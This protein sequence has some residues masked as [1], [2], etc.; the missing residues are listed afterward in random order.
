MRLVSSLTELLRSRAFRRIF[1]Y[2][3]VTILLIWGIVLFGISAMV[4]VR[5]DAASYQAI[6]GILITI[7]IGA[8]L[9]TR[10]EIFSRNAQLQAEERA[11][12]LTHNDALTSLSNR[13]QFNQS[14]NAHIERGASCSV[15]L[16]DLD[17][18]RNVNEVY[19]H[20][21]GDQVLSN[22]AKRL[23]A[24]VEKYGGQSAR[25]G[26][27]EFAALVPT[28]NVTKL[29]YLCD[30]LVESTGELIR[31]DTLA[32]QPGTSVGVAT[33]AEVAKRTEISAETM[34]RAADFALSDA[35]RRGRGTYRIYDQELAA[36]HSDNRCILDELPKAFENGEFFV[37][38]QPKVDLG[39]NTVCGF[40]ALIRWNRAGNVVPPDLFIPLAE[41]TRQV[42]QMDLFVLGEA[43]RQ[44]GEWNREFDLSLSISANL[45]ARHFEDF[46]IID[47][48]KFALVRAQ[49]D[50][51]LLTLELTETV[52]LE[53]WDKV[54]CILEQ[55][56]ELGCRTSLDDFG[57][58][59]SS[60][61][62]LRRI[63]ADELKIDRAFVIDIEESSETRVI[64]NS[65]VDI[66]RCLGMNIV[67]EGIE[68][69]GQAKIAASVGCDRAQGYLYSAPVSAGTVRSLFLDADGSLEVSV[70]DNVDRRASA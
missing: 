49:L 56:R 3:T 43:A 17:N 13:A 69:V 39:T 40:E 42:I 57:T 64:L 60:L 19:G 27:D 55:L 34:Y 47:E 4:L 31:K 30:E 23:H 52:L 5:L 15:L 28:H 21:F 48:V 14:L 16:L 25:L 70:E 41:E 11:E 68:T 61:A 2:R 22:T 50:P 59:Y 36:T 33:S 53:D 46:R 6:I 58:G 54:H 38:Y 35:K 65:I 63:K 62:Y 18:F 9:T 32:F 37:A 7:G 24:T 44:V 26:G 29:K 1:D 10:R 67:V 8:V 12:F 45:S 51:S 20:G 66:A